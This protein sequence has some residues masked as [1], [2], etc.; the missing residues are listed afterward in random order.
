MGGSLA[1]DGTVQGDVAAIGGRMALGSTARVRGDLR[2]ATGQEL[3]LAPGAQV[4]GQVLRGPAS[5]VEP[6]DLFPRREPL[7]QLPRMLLEAL[8]LGA[9]ASLTARF[10]PGPAA[11]VRRAALRYGLISAAMGLL[12]GVVGLV[13]LVVMAFTLILIPVTLLG[14]VLGFLAVGYGYAAVGLGIG[15]WL[16]ARATRPWR[17]EAA[18]FLGTF[19]FVLA[20]DLVTLLPLVGGTIGIVAAL[21]A[22]GAVLL[23]RF[24]LREFVPA[25]DVM[26]ES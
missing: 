13:L 26:G 24:G 15:R 9:L 8:F 14:F 21:V 18:A 20:L 23:T 22:F 10:I 1:L 11:N 16:S 7:A 12:A 2:A 19:V 25:F 5:G 3:A 4:E 6:G 17:R